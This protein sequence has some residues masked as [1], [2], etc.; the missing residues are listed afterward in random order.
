[1]TRLGR[2]CVLILRSTGFS[3]FIGPKSHAS[4][5]LF[6]LDR[7]YAG[8]RCSAPCRLDP[9]WG[10]A[11]SPLNFVSGTEVISQVMART[12]KFRLEKHMLSHVRLWLDQQGLLTKEEFVTPFGI[13]DVA[14]VKFNREHVRQRRV[15]GQSRS[16]GP[17]KRVNSA[18]GY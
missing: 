9:T 6:R 2:L 4:F 13:C 16:I 10:P 1:M 18:G 11:E 15:L 17:L 7:I 14:A 3:V 8:P 5:S 12:Q